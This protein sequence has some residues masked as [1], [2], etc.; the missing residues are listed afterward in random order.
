LDRTEFKDL[1][2]PIVTNVEAKIIRKGEEARDSLKRQVSRP[3]LWYKS[4]EI[5]SQEHVDTFV[6]LGSG[7][8]LTGLLKRIGRGW[9]HPF[10]VWNVE[11]AE[12][13]ERAKSSI[14]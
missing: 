9:P 12:S 13:L 7:K 4:M 10:T 2:F 3:V 5:L 14:V 11:D 8:V 6:E 1:N